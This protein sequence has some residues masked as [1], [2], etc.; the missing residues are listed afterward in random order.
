MD[1]GGLDPLQVAALL[2]SG[3]PQPQGDRLVDHRPPSRM[4]RRPG[5]LL[6][7]SAEQGRASRRRAGRAGAAA[8]PVRLG[9]GDPGTAGRARS[10]T[11]RLPQPSSCVSLQGH[12]PVGAQGR[13]GLLDRAARED[14]G[15]RRSRADRPGRR[16]GPGAGPR[17]RDKAASSGPALARHRRPRRSRRPTSVWRPS[18]RFPADSSQVEPATFAFLLGQLDREQPAAVADGRRR[19][20]V[21]GQAHHRPARDP[22]RR[23]QDRRPAGG[24]SPARRPSS[25][26]PTR[27]SA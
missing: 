23:T 27:R 20:A 13:P 12:G 19:R 10:P 14:S 1:G 4:G 18:P 5:R 2:T 26:R 15:R 25:K 21:A 3:D 8:R 24:R 7:R 16:H 11:P 6:P 17:A 22:G 9:A